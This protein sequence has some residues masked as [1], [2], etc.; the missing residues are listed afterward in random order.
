MEK[1]IRTF[2][3]RGVASGKTVT[4]EEYQKFIETTHL[5]SV[6]REWAPGMKR[7]ETEDGVPVNFID[8]TTFEIVGG[9]RLVAV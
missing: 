8:E 3:A 4:I 6:A 7:L 9:E 1:L 2:E 5:S